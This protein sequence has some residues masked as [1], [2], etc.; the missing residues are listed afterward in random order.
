MVNSWE[1]VVF[2]WS[3]IQFD[4]IFNK[5]IKKIDILEKCLV[6]FWQVTV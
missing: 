4:T 1:N 2:V 6:S 5:I 3:T